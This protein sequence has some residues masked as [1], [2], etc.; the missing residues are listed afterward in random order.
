MFI[1]LQ[2]TAQN[3]AAAAP[4]ASDAHDSIPRSKVSFTVMNALCKVV[5]SAGSSDSLRQEHHQGF[6]QQ[7]MARGKAVERTQESRVSTVVTE[8]IVDNAVSISGIE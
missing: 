2:Q 5:S 7:G 8:S 4:R 3:Q 1:G 6:H